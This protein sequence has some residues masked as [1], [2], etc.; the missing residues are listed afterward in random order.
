MKPE[1]FLALNILSALAWG[2]PISLESTT[3]HPFSSEI[4]NYWRGS[5]VSGI[6]PEYAFNV[7]VYHEYPK[8]YFNAN[9]LLVEQ[10]S[11]DLNGDLYFILRS[12]LLPL[13]CQPWVDDIKKFDCKNREQ[14]E[15]DNLV[16]KVSLFKYLFIEN[17]LN[18]RS[19]LLRLTNDSVL[20][21]TV[22]CTEKE[23]SNT[24]AV[25]VTSS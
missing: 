20:M 15:V 18:Q 11:G 17:I 1:L 25:F 5:K 13:E 12:F 2:Q 23:S 21:D 6:N 7:T 22:C 19:I 14:T 10:N 16:S 8:E 9:E 4:F 3:I 24:I